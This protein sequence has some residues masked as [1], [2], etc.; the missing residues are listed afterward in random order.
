MSRV[1]TVMKS[2]SLLDQGCEQAFITQ[3]SCHQQ[4]L[5]WY[6]CQS[7]KRFCQRSSTI[8]TLSYDTL[9]ERRSSF[10]VTCKKWKVHVVLWG[11]GRRSLHNAVVV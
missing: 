4:T 6:W 2:V 3:Q 7:D 9:A 1:L 8:L 5:A 10:S 11:V